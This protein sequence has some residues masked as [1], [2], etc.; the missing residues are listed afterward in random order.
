MLKLNNYDFEFEK[1]FRKAP[2]TINIRLKHI[3]DS[4]VELKVKKMQ[5]EYFPA[6]IKS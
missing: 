3:N 1:L 5:R 4:T 2:N 6:N